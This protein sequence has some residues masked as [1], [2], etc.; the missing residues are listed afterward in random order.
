MSVYQPKWHDWTPKEARVRTDKTDKSPSEA[1]KT[2]FVS[3]VSSIP[4]RFRGVA[5]DVRSSHEEVQIPGKTLLS[6]TDKTDRSP[7][8]TRAV[9]LAVP[10]GAPDEWVQGVADLLAAAPH[11]AWTDKTWKTL[12]DDALAFLQQWA[13][14]AHRLG[15]DGLD[16]FAVHPSAPVARLDCMGLVPLL[17]GRPVVAFTK[18]DA[19][20]KAASGGALTYRRHPCPPAGRC[21]VWE[22][23]R[24][25]PMKGTVG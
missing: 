6:L 20:I 9:L 15:W 10:E 25:V 21:L 1:P 23:A 3:F 24:S 11:P 8:P 7:R 16:L 13:G 17:K 18:D 22:L 4:G 12:Q 14:Q 5:A 2:P 19:T